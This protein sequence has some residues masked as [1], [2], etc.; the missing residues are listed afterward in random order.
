MGMV[1]KAMQVLSPEPYNKKSS[2]RYWVESG[3]SVFASG[4]KQSSLCAAGL[5]RFARNDG[6]WWRSAGD[7]R[8]VEALFARA[9]DRVVIARVGVLRAERV[10]RA[11]A[12]IYRVPAK[13][14]ELSVGARGGAG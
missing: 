4:A 10:D 3:L 2:G 13:N 1:R 7:H 11:E 9:I 8:Q 5:L 6:D 12:S 14:T